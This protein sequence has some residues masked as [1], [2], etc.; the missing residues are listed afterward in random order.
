MLNFKD[1]MF[2]FTYL[3]FFSFLFSLYKGY[4]KRNNTSSK[5]SNY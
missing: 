4:H 2:I 3:T 1:V 5:K